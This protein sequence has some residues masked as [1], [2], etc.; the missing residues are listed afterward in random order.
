MV[1]IM[2]L[3]FLTLR[4]NNEMYTGTSSIVNS[5]VDKTHAILNYKTN[6]LFIYSK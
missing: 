2:D 4:C 1:Y 3:E 6:N 5:K